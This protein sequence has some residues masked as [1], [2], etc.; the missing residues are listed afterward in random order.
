[1]NFKRF[2]LQ[3]IKQ[4]FFGRL[5]SNSKNTDRNPYFGGVYFKSANTFYLN[6][7]PL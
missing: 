1:M 7:L 2:P 4:L 3:E 5:E 6:L